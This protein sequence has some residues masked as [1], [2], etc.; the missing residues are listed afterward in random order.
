MLVF[1]TV[2][3]AS[4][5]VQMAIPNRKS[6]GH[7][8]PDATAEICAFLESQLCPHD[9]QWWLRHKTCSNTYLANCCPIAFFQRIQKLQN[10]PLL[11][12]TFRYPQASPASPTKPRR[13]RAVLHQFEQQQHNQLLGEQRLQPQEAD[14]RRNSGKLRT[15]HVW[16]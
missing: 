6:G 8:V 16:T 14:R 10:N 1:L 7:L 3:L 2:Y 5:F 13:Q 9:I 12:S 4:L 11:V 15:V